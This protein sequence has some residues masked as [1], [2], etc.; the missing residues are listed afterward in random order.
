MIGS[1]QDY[2]PAG[3]RGHFVLDAAQITDSICCQLQAQGSA[4]VG[5]SNAFDNR[6][7]AA[8]WVV[9]SLRSSDWLT[10]EDRALIASELLPLW[11]APLDTVRPAR[12]RPA[13]VAAFH[14]VIRDDDLKLLDSIIEGIKVA[15]TAGFFLVPLGSTALGVAVAGLATAFLKVAYNAWTRGVKLTPKDYALFASLKQ[16]QAGVTVEDLAV[17]FG[18]QDEAWTPDAV[19]AGLTR[20]ME[21]PSPSGRIGLV[22]Q[23]EGRWRVAGA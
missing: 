15:A 17:K 2:A 3:E 9:A 19:R 10:V 5:Q 14:W 20:L 6:D 13:H 1:C 7:A 11:Q 4:H 12:G 18:S 16:S 23:T 8:A 22:W 21:A